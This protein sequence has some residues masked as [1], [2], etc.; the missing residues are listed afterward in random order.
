MADA[1]EADYAG[2]EAVRDPLHDS[3]GPEVDGRGIEVVRS[4]PPAEPGPQ[5]SVWRRHRLSILIALAITIVGAV[6]GG[7]VG[8]TV[9]SPQSGETGSHAASPTTASTR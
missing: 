7:A 9:G 3:Y 8:G 6:V 2:K 1:P 5:S 4:L